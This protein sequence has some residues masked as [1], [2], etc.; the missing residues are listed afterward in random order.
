MFKTICENNKKEVS[1][2]TLGLLT[3]PSHPLFAS[4]PTEGHTD[5]Q[6]WPVVKES[7][8]LILDNLPT[9]YR[10][11]VQVIDNIERNHKLGLVMEFA[12][13]KG[14]LLLCMSNLDAASRRPE[15]RAFYRSLLA[16]MHS[17]RFHPT[18]SFR[19]AELLPLLQQKVGD[20]QLDE[21]N[22][23]SPY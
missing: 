22:N 2:G 3:D 12:V 11:L 6:W 20:R 13:G 4:F 1:P 15:G 23:I 16:Y 7:T 14:R 19:L 18:T 9:S 17:D 5:W 10:P 21:L 8:P